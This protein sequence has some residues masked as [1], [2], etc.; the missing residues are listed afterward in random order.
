[1]INIDIK[2]LPHGKNIP[3]PKYQTH[4]A[5]GM[6]IMAAIEELLTL[7]TGKTTIIPTG[8][9]IA[10]PENYE[11]QIRSRSGLAAKHG[12]IVLNSPGTIDS[13]YRGE[14]KIILINHGQHDF[15]IKR[16][17]RIAQMIIAPITKINWHK[18]DHLSE[19]IR[20]TGGFGSTDPS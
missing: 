8:F 10:I 4:G 3:V 13:D 20:G 11:G 5:A 15:I 17:D 12:I 2:M 19:T 14:L 1:M 16:G 6:D 7:Q 9:T 18:V